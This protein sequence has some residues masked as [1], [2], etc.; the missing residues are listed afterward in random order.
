MAVDTTG[1][2]LS[3]G[4]TEP[5]QLT[6]V[7]VPDIYQ[8]LG[9]EYSHRLF[10]RILV[11]SEAS[12]TLQDITWRQLLTDTHRTVASLK[13][14]LS[15]VDDS[16]TSSSKVVGLLAASNYQY[17]VQLVALWF[18]GWA[19]LLLSP[20]NSPQAIEH[21]L[22]TSSASAL[23]VGYPWRDTGKTM[24]QAIDGLIVH[25]MEP[26]LAGLP[27]D[28][29]EG[30]REEHAPRPMDLDSVI[31]YT[32]TS[33]SQGHPKLIPTTQ[34]RFIAGIRARSA[35]QYAGSSIYAPL[36]L[37]HGM[38]LYAFTRWPLGSGV[39]PTFIEMSGPL[40]GSALLRHL[41]HLPGAIA[42]LAPSVLEEI[43]DSPGLDLG[44]LVAAKRV[45]FG[46]APMNPNAA[47]TLINHGVLL[48]SAYGSSETS[49]LSVFDLP[50][51]DLL[52][53]WFYIRF[54]EDHYT[55]HLL[56]VDG[57]DSNVRELVVSPSD[58]DSPAVLNHVDPVGFATQDLWAPH[59]TRRGL[60]M[61]MG[62]KDDVTVLSNGEKTDNKQIESLLQQDSRIKHVLVFGTGKAFNGVVLNP[63]SGDQHTLDQANF[64]ASVWPTIE[65]A[66]DII[67][68]HSRILPQMVLVAD[69]HKPF[70][71]SDKG[72][73][74]RKE[75]LELYATSI[76]TAYK[77]LE[78]APASIQ[79]EKA[80]LQDPADVL[81]FIRNL[82]CEQLA[83]KNLEDND[84]FFESGLD[85]L[86]AFQVRALLLRGTNITELPYNVAYTHPTISRL[87]AFISLT[88]F[89]QAPISDAPQP[90]D[91]TYHISST[92]HRFTSG[93]SPFVRR[94]TTEDG[95]ESDGLSV[96]ISGSTGSLGSHVLQSLLVRSD[97]IRVFCLHR[98]DPG[99]AFENQKRSFM[100]RGIPVEVLVRQRSKVDFLRADFSRPLVGLVQED[101][102]KVLAHATHII[103]TAWQLNFNL[104]LEQFAEVHVAGV[105]HLIDLALSSRRATPPKL[106]FLSSI[107]A[108][109]RYSLSSAV[110]EQIFSDATLP[111]TEGYA[112]AKFVAERVINEACERCG[113]QAA[114]IRAGQ[115]SG[116]SVSGFWTATEYIPILFASSRKLGILPNDF[117]DTHW[118]PV[119]IAADA[120][121]ALSLH[122]EALPLACYH[123]ENPTAT[124]WGNAL[125]LYSQTLGGGIKTVPTKDWLSAVEGSG[126]LSS[127][128]SAIPAIQLLQ[129]YTDFAAATKSW[130][131]LD[132]TKARAIFPG[133]DYGTLT[134]TL[135]QSYVTWMI[136]HQ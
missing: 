21:L 37:F 17:F 133:I 86:H 110:P 130:V 52:Q 78:E 135:I 101:L 81:R 25:E 71:L 107:A 112:E 7:T 76:T 58:K 123:L 118:L 18:L 69:E 27:V 84:N 97:V 23:I 60:W 114:I 13:S 79:G 82:I 131:T 49:L 35:Q 51:E 38:G 63:N 103:H 104:P 93:L 127:M 122:K 54:Q 5:L 108:V 33:G 4:P 28:T 3:V 1:P 36:P 46:G 87:S 15:P 91:R 100:E 61:H 9:R 16:P 57:P 31:L 92:I 134:P 24:Q 126:G 22:K 14:L 34:K 80:E 65:H 113:L 2:L 116:S 47:R 55:I 132:V 11:D 111:A 75:T 42:F 128:A 48:G 105:R 95:H 62:R 99:E 117:P 115:L 10:A 120:V 77:S 56:P 41:E 29:G 98:G 102:N 12:A 85:S 43:A 64:L 129:F 96:V 106:V 20:R 90:L 30:F 74:R 50:S 73:V 121:I 136:G 89:G 40:D 124:T 8:Q 119:D 66:N 6:D 83:R 26:D 94:V 45:F 59:P 39:V 109:S 88:L 68:R 67:P 32:H 70:V 125:Q 72:T 53:D 19:P 44:P